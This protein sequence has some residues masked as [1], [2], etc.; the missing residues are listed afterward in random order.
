[1]KKPERREKQE[2]K[3]LKAKDFLSAGLVNFY[4]IKFR[5]K[6]SVKLE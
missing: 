3:K 1:M 6:K 2:I 5:K 4:G